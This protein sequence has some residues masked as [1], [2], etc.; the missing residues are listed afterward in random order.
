[1]LAFRRTLSGLEV[2]L[3]HPGGPFWARRDLGIWSIPKGLFDP[4]LE[5]PLEAANREFT[6]ETGFIVD[7]PFADLGTLRQR[8]GKIVHAFAAEADFDAASSRSNHFEMEWPRGSGTMASFPEVDRSEWFGLRE[9]RLK[10]L[11]GQLVFL[12]RLVEAVG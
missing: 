12:D 4:E 10:L 6:E 2:L 7:G 3:V 11:P 1:M 5:Q 8:S 9:A